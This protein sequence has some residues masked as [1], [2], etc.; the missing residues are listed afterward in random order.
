[1]Q[2]YEIMLENL[3][4]SIAKYNYWEEKTFNLGFIR[5]QYLTKISKYLNNRL[6]KVLL[7]QRRSGKS[8]LLRQIIHYLITEK[9]IKPQNIFYLNKEFIGLDAIKNSLDLNNLFLFYQKKLSISGKIYIF[10]D[11][12]QNILEWE[13]FVNSY[14]Q[15]FTNEYEFFITGSNSTLLSGE[16][17]TLLSGRYVEFQIFPYN[18][19][20]F[21]KVYQLKDEK[22]SYLNYLQI[23][24]LPEIANFSEPE[25]T[26]N[27]VE[28]LKNTIILRDIIERY[29][30]KDVL[31]LENL[32]KFLLANIGN[33]TSYSTIVKY[34]KSQNK[35]TNYETISN[36]VSYIL[37][38]FAFYEA[39]RFDLKGKQILSGVRKF[40]LND[41]AFRY[42]LHGFK[43]QDFGYILENLIYIQLKNHG[44]KIY[45][46]NLNN[47]E[48]DF[49][50]IKNEQTIYVQV[51]YMLSNEDTIQREFGNLQ[52]IS[53]NYP[54]LV[55]SLDD[56]QFT[57]YEGIKHI[58]AWKFEQWLD[59]NF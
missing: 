37:D 13:K 25:I 53:D 27:Y 8:F 39:E 2:I 12:V 44:F 17:A 58:Q 23:G 29:A 46:G 31:L 42:Y 57:D 18:Y 55:I 36:Y 32:F 49:V 10:L 26:R 24:G 4:Q 34:F 30:I 43:S 5:Q 19:I 52:K 59:D 14:S 33:L 51:A 45:I 40:Y 38:T 48:I 6:I 50:A 47:L 16:L 1:M 21:L 41:L 9:Q 7:G 3:F 56:F 11:E 15:D 28:S 22:N 54:K 35:R 20:E